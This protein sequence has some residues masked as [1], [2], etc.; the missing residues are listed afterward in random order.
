MARAT[1]CLRASAETAMRLA[2]ICTDRAVAM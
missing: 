2:A 1:A